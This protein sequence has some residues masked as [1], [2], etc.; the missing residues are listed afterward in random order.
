MNEKKTDLK[1]QVQYSE[2]YTI[3]KKQAETS[4]PT[5]K[6]STYNDNIAISAHAK[7]LVKQ[8]T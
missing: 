8:A 3:I 1:Q 2:K 5:W 6:V 7:K 4:W